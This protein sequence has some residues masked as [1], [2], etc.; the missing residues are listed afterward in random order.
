MPVQKSV[1]V[2][3]GC[4]DRVIVL[5]AWL[6]FRGPDLPPPG[7]LSHVHNKFV[8]TDLLF[9]WLV[10]LPIIQSVTAEWSVS[11]SASW[12]VSQTGELQCS[13]S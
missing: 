7:I 5:I 3:L 13:Q 2:S 1:G 11:G 12:L 8:S 4:G 9:S 6:A 10:N